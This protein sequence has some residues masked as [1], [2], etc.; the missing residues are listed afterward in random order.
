[1]EQ[2]KSLWRKGSRIALCMACLLG[3]VMISTSGRS[4]SVSNH[5]SDLQTHR[6]YSHRGEPDLEK[7]QLEQDVTSTNFAREAQQLF[8]SDQDGYFDTYEAIHDSDPF[9]NRSHPSP[10][11]YVDATALPGG[12]GSMEW[13]FDTIQQAINAAIDF[14]IIRLAD[15]TYVGP[16]N[17]NLNFRGKPIML[18]SKHGPETCLIDCEGNGRGV[19]FE[20]K[21]SGFSVL[22]GISFLNGDV[23]QEDGGAIH[24]RSTSPT[25]Q[26][27]LFLNNA[28]SRGGAIFLEASSPLIQDSFVFI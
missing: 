9:D 5:R 11:V 26:N 3:L 16:E 14:D 13:P 25:I 6:F 23:F 22:W 8:D 28:A 4:T 19:L 18:R 21:E 17:K 24:T 10:S 1:M 12:N 27:C 15:G 2:V 7:T 20:Q